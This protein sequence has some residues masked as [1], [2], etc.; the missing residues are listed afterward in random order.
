MML[1]GPV[2]DDPQLV[3]VG[4]FAGNDKAEVQALV[5]GDPAAQAGQV[6]SPLAHS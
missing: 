3:G 6:I 2:T 1:N 4:I 5:D